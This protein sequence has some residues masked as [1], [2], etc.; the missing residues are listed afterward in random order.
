MKRHNFILLTVIFSCILLLTAIDNAFS[1]WDSGTT[2]PTR[3]TTTGDADYSH[4]SV[5]HDGSGGFY[6]VWADCRN[7]GGTDK[8]VYAQYYNSNGNPQWTADGLQIGY[9]AEGDK[10]PRVVSNGGRGIIVSWTNDDT[11]MAIQRVSPSGNLTWASGTTVAYGYEST[12]SA[13]DGA[14]GII[15]VCSDEG[16]AQRINAAGTPLWGPN[17][18][19]KDGGLNFSNTIN[20]GAQLIDDGSGGAMIAWYDDSSNIGMQRISAAGKIL[21]MA[22]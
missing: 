10:K 4:H 2:N 7:C 11:N 8:D 3:V 13:S 22:N 5:L 20:C 15:V 12:R 17:P 14:G 6:V 16:I 21:G 9:L 18:A 1:D 19:D